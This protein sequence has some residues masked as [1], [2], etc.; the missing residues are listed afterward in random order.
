MEQ[1]R[2]GYFKAVFRKQGIILHFLPSYGILNAFY[3]IFQVACAPYKPNAFLSFTRMLSVNSRILRDFIRLMKLDMVN[4]Q[5][6]L[7]ELLNVFHFTLQYP[8]QSLKW[9]VHFCVS[10]PPNIIGS[11]PGMSACLLIKNKVLIFVRNI[12]HYFVELSYRNCFFCR[13]NFLGILNSQ[14]N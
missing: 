12:P 6:Y 5:I 3:I 14:I 9:C 7:T 2:V 10:I 8:D 11:P 4:W 1:R 13:F